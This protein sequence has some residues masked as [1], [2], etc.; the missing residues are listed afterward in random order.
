MSEDRAELAKYLNTLREV[1]DAACDEAFAQRNTLKGAINWGDLGCVSAEYYV[2]ADGGEG[3]R[4]TIE[5]ADPW[6]TEL[7]EF[8]QTKITEAGY[9]DIEIYT[10]W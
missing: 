2:D 6:N 1:A 8:I 5:E 7:H 4:I 10:E 9:A 3:Y